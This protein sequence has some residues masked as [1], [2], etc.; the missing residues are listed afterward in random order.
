MVEEKK[1]ERDVI[2]FSIMHEQPQ[3]SS[4]FL[5]SNFKSNK[6][7]NSLPPKLGENLVARH[8]KVRMLF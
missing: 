8:V 2:S 6:K 3:K 1:H 7:N 4:S 5:L